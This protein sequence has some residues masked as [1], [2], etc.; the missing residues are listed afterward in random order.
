MNYSKWIFNV[1]E[2]ALPQKKMTSST[3]TAREKS[4]ASFKAL[5]D[6][7][8]LLLGVNV[9]GNLKLKSVVTSQ[10]PNP[11]T[12]KNLDCPYSMCSLGTL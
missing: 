3:F 10:S 11:R 2:I 8:A 7:L 12:L 6:S 5:K 9:V 1:D 4:I